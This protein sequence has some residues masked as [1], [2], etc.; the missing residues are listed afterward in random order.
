MKTL[1]DASATVTA[2]NGSA[3]AYFCLYAV[4]D[5]YSS[6]AVGWMVATSETTALA[7]ALL[8][9]TLAKDWGSQR[10]EFPP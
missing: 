8:A 1:T 2:R 3:R 4:T 7:E 9:G 6:K 5:V 10:R